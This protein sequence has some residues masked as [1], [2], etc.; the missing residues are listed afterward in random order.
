[1]YRIEEILK[2]KG[3][4]KVD[5]AERMNTSKQSLNSLINGNPTRLKLE[6]MASALKVPTWQLFEDP[7]NIGAPKEFF[8]FI[9]SDGENYTASSPDELKAIIEQL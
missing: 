3:L 7:K 1:M 5:L 2:E 9:H 4:S 8:A 6:E